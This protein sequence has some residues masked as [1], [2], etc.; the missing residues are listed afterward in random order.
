MTTTTTDQSRDSLAAKLAKR[1]PRVLV[2]YIAGTWGVVQF[3][4]WAANRY[5]LSPHLVE[6][7]VGVAVT[8]L[9]TVLL[10]AYYRGEHGRTPWTRAE[11]LGIPC[12]L[13]AALV[14]LVIVFHARE[15]GAL[16][17]KVE[18]TNANG[19]TVERQVP[20]SAFR[21]HV[22]LFFLSNRSGDAQDDWLGH[23]IADLI[24]ID[25]SQDLFVDSRRQYELA[26][27]IKKA[28]ATPGD[29]L[30]LG[31]QQELARGANLDFI[32]FGSFTRQGQ[33]FVVD[34]S[35][36]RTHR[37]APIAERHHRGPD[38]FKLVDEASLQLRRDLGIP[39]AEI[40]SA[41]DLPVAEIMTH[42]LA[43]LRAHTLGMSQWMIN[44][45]ARASL[46]LFEQAVKIDPTFAQAWFLQAMVLFW[47]NRQA[48][49]APSMAAVKKNEYRL[50][51]QQRFSFESM[52]A[53]LGKDPAA[54]LAI[55]RQWVT[56]YPDDL[57]AHLALMS[58]YIRRNRLDEAKAEAA[59]VI[60]LDPGN[61]RYL[62]QLGR[63]Y[64]MKGDNASAVQQYLSYQKQAPTDPYGYVRAAL[65]YAKMARLD[66]AT[67]SYDRALAVAPEDITAIVGMSEVQM[68][69]G[70]MDLAQATLDRG[71]KQ[72]PGDDDKVRLF[73]QQARLWGVQGKWQRAV[74]EVR[75]SWAIL[76]ATQRQMTFLQRQ[77]GQ[78][79]IL[80]NAGR[81]DEALATIHQAEV[82]SDNV[83]VT[84][85]VAVA[86]ADVYTE[87]RDAARA[88][89][90]IDK[91][92]ALIKTYDIEEMQGVTADYRG[93]AAEIEGAF[94]AALASYE[95][96]LAQDPSDEEMLVRV[97]RCRRMLKQYKDAHELLA[98]ALARFPAMPEAHAELARLFV[99][100]GDRKQ[101]GVEIA[102]ALKVWADADPGYARAADA[103]KLAAELRAHP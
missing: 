6:L 99:D 14:V 27:E 2:P 76:K 48:Q 10:L 68:Q 57:Q 65:V 84:I 70:R 21:K 86:L 17:R 30:P 91:L 89:A 46:P 52:N 75:K 72:S 58:T 62:L 12:N 28:G 31:L 39:A 50:S 5:M 60:A 74:D 102:A 32:V 53:V 63:V 3:V 56:L 101:A 41:T 97:A 36:A 35:L 22:A 78:M 54:E 1:L 15:L 82:A 9:P 93:R 87:L 37:G 98:R 26:D 4:D 18:L 44:A 80:V 19:N 61:P 40:E 90:A 29:A 95:A 33:D 43:A 71:L 79:L 7:V 49:M 67:K 69:T 38:L 64:E 81:A 20:K 24:S 23:A 83:N 11:K 34:L 92:D 51:E 42:S 85:V 59:Q 66:D 77:L 100:E 96:A 55:L 8:L 73:D 16:T 103:Q 13:V 47:D 25:M 45:D 88:R 94:A